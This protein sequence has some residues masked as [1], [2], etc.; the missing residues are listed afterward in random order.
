MEVEGVF[1]IVQKHSGQRGAM[2]SIL[3]E[4]QATYGY[5]P[6]DALKTVAEATG[7]S[8]VDVYGIAT[9]YRAFS[10]KP[11]G[12]HLCTVCVGT[13][14]HVRG[15]PAIAGEFEKQLDVRRGETTADEEFTLETVNCLGACALGPIVVVD[16]HYF[17]NVS[18]GRVKDVVQQAQAGFDARPSGDERVFPLNVSCPRCNHSLMDAA[19]PLEGHG[20]IG[21]V[22][23]SGQQTGWLRLSALYGTH[24]F[25]TE[26]GFSTGTLA[27]LFCPHCA[28]ELRGGG[29]CPDCEAPF[30][31]LIV[32]GGAI[33]QVC[34][35]LGCQGHLLDVSGVNA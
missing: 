8:L 16:G 15:A 5:L 34:S 23:S 1:R 32:E 6:A 35:R 31:P 2:I 9:F 20:A 30:V 29:V 17:S 13:A 33:L 11:R 4:V 28:S 26:H 19:H 10:L 7:R 3:E 25:E 21:L 22:V 14:C 24:T 18:T 12:K 27:Q